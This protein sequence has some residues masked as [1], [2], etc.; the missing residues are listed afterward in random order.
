MFTSQI[1]AGALGL[2]FL[3]PGVDC[4][5]ASGTDGEAGKQSHR[6][7]EQTETE[8]DEGEKSEK[9]KGFYTDGAFFGTPT[10]TTKE[11]V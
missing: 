9:Q 8:L 5:A 1:K 2:R 11:A 10:L 6:A 7:I 4:E 3:L